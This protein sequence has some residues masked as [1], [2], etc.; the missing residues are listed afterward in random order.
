[1]KVVGF[2]GSPRK[3][4]NTETCVNEILA[5]AAEKGAETKLFNI[6]HMNIKA[7][8]G[9]LACMTKGHCIVQDDFQ[10]VVKEIESSDAI[11]IGSPV[12]MGQ[13]SAQTKAMFDRFC[14]YL[15]PDFSSRVKKGT[16]FVLAFTQKQPDINWIMP[17]VDATGEMFKFLGFMPLNKLVVGGMM[18]PDDFKKNQAEL[19][20][21]RDVGRKI[22]AVMGKVPA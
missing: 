16:G 1:M 12:Y 18:M 9:C 7:C 3:G 20:M 15:N 14:S 21:A 5:G 11:V 8:Q 4:G 10:Q 6:A 17:Y 13:M 22:I 2:V 19:E